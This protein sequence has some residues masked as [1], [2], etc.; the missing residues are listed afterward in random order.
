MPN[1]IFLEE[2]SLYRKFDYNL[3]PIVS[4]PKLSINM[5]CHNC[6]D[7]RTFIGMNAFYI[8][9]SENIDCDRYRETN[10]MPKENSH[11]I[12]RY[13]CASCKKFER[14][15]ILRVGKN[16]KQI[17]KIGQYP[18]RDI[19][20]SKDLEKIMGVF[21]E[22]YKKGLICEFQGY[23]IGAN[24]Y[25]RRIVE[26]IIDDLLVQI[27]DLMSGEERALYENALEESRKAKNT[28]EKIAL[29]KDLLPPILMPERY[30][31]LKT[32]HEVLS[33]GIHNLTD[34]ECL[35]N[36]QII[37]DTLIFLINSILKRKKEQQEFSEGMKKLLEKKKK[38]TEIKK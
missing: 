35:E 14:F 3:P 15:F 19:T 29:V 22:Y 4:F 30:N 8:E 34:E 32:L 37:K 36:A 11:Y 20:I 1:A 33:K 7:K 38:T 28:Q 18:P 21:S 2:Y 31:P 26:G 23:G 16:L 12:L 25:F 9:Q 5:K 27:P 24:A 6:N 17:L 13:V 10:R